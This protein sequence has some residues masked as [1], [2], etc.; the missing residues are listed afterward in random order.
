MFLPEDYSPII[1]SGIVQDNLTAI[2]TNLPMAFQFHL[3]YLTKDGSTTSFAV[4]TRPQVS[5]NMDFCLLLITAT[6]MIINFINNVIDAKHLNCPLSLLSFFMQQKQ[7][8]QMKL[9]Q[10][11]TSNSRICAT[12]FVE[13]QRLY[14]WSVQAFQVNPSSSGLLF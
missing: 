13:N 6:G 14:C 5:V 3:P 2:T 10:Q 11:T 4:A 7:C 9:P 1:L 8:L 12:H